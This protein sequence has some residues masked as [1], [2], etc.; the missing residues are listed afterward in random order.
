[1]VTHTSTHE[2]PYNYN[3]SGLSNVLLS[4][5]TVFY[6]TKCGFDMPE[7]PRIVELHHGITR[8]LVDKETHLTGEEIKF[9]RKSLGY[10]LKNFSE[11]VETPQETLNHIEKT[12]K[13]RDD[14]MRITFFM[15]QWVWK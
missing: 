6:C 5:I 14:P 12:L 2:H 1:M 13:G 8:Y 15:D 11:L 4:G 10:S 7:I 9:I 3:L